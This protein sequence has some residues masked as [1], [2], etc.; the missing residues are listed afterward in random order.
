MISRVLLIS[1]RLSSSADVWGSSFDNSRVNILKQIFLARNMIFTNK[2]S[3][4]DVRV[5]I[6]KSYHMKIIKVLFDKEISSCTAK[7]M[8]GTIIKVLFDKETPSCIASFMN[9]TII[10]VLFDKETPSC[11]A[12][13]MNGTVEGIQLWSLLEK[14]KQFFFLFLQ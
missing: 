1:L 14:E 3:P 2:F 9:G 5:I 4:F 10:K 7:F 6:C 11:I 8:N 13:F 12:R